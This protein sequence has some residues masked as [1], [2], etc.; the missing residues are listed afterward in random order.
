VS[1]INWP[2][3]LEVAGIG[4]GFGALLG[5]MLSATLPHR[6]DERT[7]SNEQQ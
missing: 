6:A 5:L 3:A 1:A 2:F 4:G 7:R